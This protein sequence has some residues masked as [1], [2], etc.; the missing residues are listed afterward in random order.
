MT[1]FITKPIAEVILHMNEVC[2]SEQYCFFNSSDYMELL[3]YIAK[4]YPELILDKERFWHFFDDFKHYSTQIAKESESLES[5]LEDVFANVFEELCV[6][7]T[8]IDKESAIK[9]I[10]KQFN[11]DDANVILKRISTINIKES[12]NE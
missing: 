4:T 6:I 1:I 11:E 8:L 10:K 2:C 5:I 12:E 7:K 3:T 9:L